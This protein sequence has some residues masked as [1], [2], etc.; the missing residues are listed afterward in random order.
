MSYTFAIKNL[1]IMY[2]I[3]Q[4]EKR[5]H[6]RIYEIIELDMESGMECGG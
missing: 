6:V 5:Y 1:P 3:V 2:E 4:M